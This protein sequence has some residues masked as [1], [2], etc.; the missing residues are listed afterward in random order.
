MWET[1]EHVEIY[2]L[3]LRLWTLFSANTSTVDILNNNHALPWK[4]EEQ[5]VE[6]TI[7]KV[8]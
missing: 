5:A 6:L 8:A 4:G 3:W 1:W 2:G 7:A